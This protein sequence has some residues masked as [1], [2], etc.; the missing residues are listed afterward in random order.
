MKYFPFF[1]E[2]S[3]QSV[4]LIGGGEVAE[5]KLDLLLKANAS[6]TIVSPEFTSYIEELFVNKNINPIK[7]YYNI[8]YL[9]SSSFAFVIAATND[10]SL[11]EQVAKDANDN[12]ILVNVVDKPKICDFIFPSILERGPIT[13]AVSTGGSSPVLAR[14]LRTKLET[15]IPGAYGR[16]AKIVSENRIPVRKKLVNSKS[17]GIFWEQMLNGKFLELVLSGQDE[18]A[19]K[20]L[21][22]EIDNFDEQKK[23]EGEVYLVGAGPG[24]PD[25]LTFRAL[26]LMQ[27]ADVAL[28]DRLVHP[29]IIDLI[30]RDA[31]KI[32]VGKQRDNH[33]IRQEEINELLVKYAKEGKRVL[34][35]K[36]GD[37]FIFGRGGEEIDSLVDNNISFQVVPGITSASG[38]SAYSGIPLTH[39]DH[40]QS[41][42]FVTGHLKEGKLDLNWEK[43]IQ[44]NQTIVFYMGLVSID[45][46]CSQLIKFGLDPKTPCALVE[47]GTTRNQKVYTSTVDEMNNLVEQEKPSAPTIFIIGHVVTLRDK[48]NWYKSD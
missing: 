18:E 32:Y 38:C 20:F 25:L 37:P 35:L 43:L 22:I 12:K 19:V 26:R 29:S 44:P 41:C 34:R 3:K 8:K 10:E 33:T 4:L 7:D 48:L 36:G 30:R 45:I 9:T 15:M 27:Q 13:V 16:L 46:I 24:D 28:Y 21:N 42:I 39:R 6:V 1:M 11:N 14:M 5:R 17:N 47:Q 40:A 31:E 23:G 2:L